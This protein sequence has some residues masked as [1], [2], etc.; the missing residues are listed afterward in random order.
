[1]PSHDDR[2]ERIIVDYNDRLPEIAAAGEDI[3]P[4]SGWVIIGHEVQSFQPCR[5]D[6]PL[7]LNGNSPGLP[8]IMAAYYQTRQESPPYA[9]LFMSLAGAYRPRSDAGFAYD[10][11]A[12]FSASQLLEVD[13]RGY[14]RNEIIEIE[15]PLP[16]ERIG[17]VIK[18]SGKA[19]G[20]WYFEGDFPLLLTDAAGRVLARGFATAQ[21]DWMS[22]DWV[23]FTGRVKV[24]KSH[25]PGWGWLG[26]KKDNPSDRPELDDAVAI[27]V[28]LE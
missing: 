2:Q 3:Q 4:V 7:W 17:D 27:P 16:G 8:D 14:C 18:V 11:F 22:A 1:M 9:P 15:R 20:S 6:E 24:P 5:D 13:P 28:F 25:A 26:F 21:S 19:K 23:P 10:Y 12:S